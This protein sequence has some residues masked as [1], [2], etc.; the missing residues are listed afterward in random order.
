MSTVKEALQKTAGTSADSVGTSP[1]QEKNSSSTKKLTKKAAKKKDE[2]KTEKVPHVE[3][4]IGKIRKEVRSLKAELKM[5]EKNYTESREEHQS[6]L[7]AVDDINN[8]CR[9]LRKDN[10]LLLKESLL[11]RNLTAILVNM[12]NKKESVVHG[13]V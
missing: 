10:D 8:I 4:K 3:T 1:S 7:K 9:E 2:S 12:I 5:T 6:A 13:R 11:F